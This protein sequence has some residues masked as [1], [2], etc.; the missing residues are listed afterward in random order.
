[1]S[2]QNP[3]CTLMKRIN[4]DM[5]RHVNNL[6]NMNDLTLSQFDV[7]LALNL[8]ENHRM[9]LKE[10][11]RSIHVAQSTTAG[12]VSRLEKK[13]LVIYGGLPDDLRVKTVQLTERGVEYCRM[14]EKDMEQAEYKL[15]S[16]LT[17]TERGIFLTLLEK[18]GN[19]L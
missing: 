14:A 8:A 15:L 10:L 7:L 13:G 4:D 17:D 18:V 5:A 2:R 9:T 3:F 16:G 1:M 11:E 19:S 12:I 6:L